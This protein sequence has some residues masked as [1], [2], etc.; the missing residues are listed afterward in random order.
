MSGA[1]GKRT[2]SKARSGL[3]SSLEESLN[4][5]EILNSDAMEKASPEAKIQLLA[6][7]VNNI[8]TKFSIM[9]EIVNEASDRLDP[10][11]TDN[12]EKIQSLVDE[13]RQLCFE[14]DI[15]Q[16]CLLQVRE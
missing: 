11:T 6:D 8:T 13:N 10:R 14:L 7:A 12:E 1:A 4:K 16:R 5:D 2:S 9:H 3:M 15:Y